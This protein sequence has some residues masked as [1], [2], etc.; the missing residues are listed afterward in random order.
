MITNLESHK[1]NYL[2]VAVLI[3]SFLLIGTGWIARQAVGQNKSMEGFV[4]FSM[5]KV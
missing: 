4:K 5:E 1:K 3:V 2:L